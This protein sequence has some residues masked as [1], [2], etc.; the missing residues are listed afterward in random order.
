MRREQ[1]AEQTMEIKYGEKVKTYK[2]RVKDMKEECA[3]VMG[4]IG[5]LEEQLREHREETAKET[6]SRAP[7]QRTG[8]L[9]LGLIHW[10]KEGLVVSSLHNMHIREQ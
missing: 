5:T 3:Q 10:S 6:G 1:E 7:R 9:L 4:K 8:G 2:M